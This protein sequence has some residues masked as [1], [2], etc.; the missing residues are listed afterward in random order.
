[1]QTL[2]TKHIIITVHEDDPYLYTENYKTFKC[3]EIK[4]VCNKLL[5]IRNLA[6]DRNVLNHF[7]IFE[8]S[9]VKN[10]KNSCFCV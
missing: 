2:Q 6:A 5:C 7:K 3:L 4:D 8:K 9:M 10:D 1:M